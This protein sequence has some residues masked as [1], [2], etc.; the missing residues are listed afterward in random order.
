MSEITVA[1]LRGI[2]VG[3]RSSLPMG[4]LRT[5]LG[6]LGAGPVATYIQS[7]NVAF[8]GA[9]PAD[10]I[11]DAIEAEKGFRPHVLCL[12][13]DDY[14]AILA[15]N[16]YRDAAA[17]DGKAVHVVFLDGPPQALSEEVLALATP[18]EA[19]AVADRAAYLLAP[20]GIGR[21]KLAARLERALGVPA[22]ARN[23][24]SA[25]KIADMAR[26]LR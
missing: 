24:T 16:P 12:S 18:S 14:E 3:G 20:E 2:N 11:S 6:R 26:G 23:W 22:T 19:V 7:G 1:L 15:A 5:M 21:S 10:A 4:E 25:R 13:L 8:R 17:A 9:I